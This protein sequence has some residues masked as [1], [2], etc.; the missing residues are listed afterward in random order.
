MSSSAL[1]SW[2]FNADYLQAC[3]C[4]YGCP[5]EF[6]APP[7]PGFCESTGT[8]LIKT[9]HCGNVSLDGLAMAFAAHWPKA[10]HLGGGTVQIFIDERANQEQREALENI[11]FGKLRGLPFEILATTFTTVQP[12]VFV[13][14]E[15]HLDGRNSTARVG[16]Q[17]L[18][19][20]EPVKNPVTGGPEFVRIEHATGFVFKGAEVVSARDLRVACGDINFQYS[21][22]AGFVTEI[23]YHN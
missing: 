12:T 11:A 21:N 9:G 15:I 6:A 19:D 16:D 5:C 10:I 18:F 23:H 4:D 3:N 14:I 17:I 13:P 8:W 2:V 1:L 7:T 22:K 20:L